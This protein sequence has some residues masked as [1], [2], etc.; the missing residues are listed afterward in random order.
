MKKGDKVHYVVHEVHSKQPNLQGDFPWVHGLKTGR[1]DRD[2]KDEVLELTANELRVKLE[3]VRRTPEAH[4]DRV[5]KQLVLLRPAFTWAA[6]VREVRTVDGRQVADLDITD[7]TSIM[8]LHYDGVPID[9]TK[10]QA[11]SC[12]SAV[13][14]AIPAPALAPAAPAAPPAEVPEKP[15]K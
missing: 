1:K 10:S 5:M 13:Q 12:H 2:G 8:T 4:R 11:H 7:A 6:T 3:G 14:A 9:E 15:K